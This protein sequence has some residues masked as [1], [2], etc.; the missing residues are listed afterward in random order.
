M[1]FRCSPGPWSTGTQGGDGQVVYIGADMVFLPGSGPVTRDNAKL[2]AAA[3]DLFEIVCGFLD[4]LDTTGEAGAVA[5]AFL[6]AN[7]GLF[8]AALDLFDELVEEA[9]GYGPPREQKSI[10]RRG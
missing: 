4:T 3:P 10:F 1:T 2:I 5:K 9:G 6:D 8:N 7:P